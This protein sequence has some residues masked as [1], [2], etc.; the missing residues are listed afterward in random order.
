MIKRFFPYAVVAGA[1]CALVAM[2]GPPSSGGGATTLAPVRNGENSPL[3]GNRGQFTAT[4]SLGGPRSSLQ[5]TSVDGA[6][7][8]DALGAPAA[9][10][11]LR[12][13]FDYFISRIGERTE[14][15]IRSDIR[16][17]LSARL[18]P[19]ALAQVMAWFDAYVSVEKAAAGLARQG[20]DP[21]L[22]VNALRS[23]RRDRM[24][25]E[26]ADAWWGD[27]DRYLDYTLA[28]EDVLKSG[29]L[30]EHSRQL[31][32]DE[33]DETLDKARADQRKDEALA[34]LSFVQS[35]DYR[36]RQVLPSE[37]YA[38]R[39]KQYGAAAA[40]RLAALDLQREQ[41]DARLRRYAHQR[42]QILGDGDTPSAD[43]S[44][45]LAELRRHSFNVKEQ[46]RVDA[47]DRNGALP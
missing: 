31:K 40:Q 17:Y 47:L 39:Q 20:G 12:R 1:L 25:P 45:R 41:W 19:Q 22:A 32:L 27:E 7:R 5:G 3:P 6:I 11:E 29:E 36:L 2:W 4:G 9:D 44:R 38:E 16:A 42:R 35:E 10:R 46:L 26:I 23:L 37:R 8:L 43:Q 24:G 18:T 21:R 15:Q 33:L 13:L 28:R 14:Q 34:E 30:D